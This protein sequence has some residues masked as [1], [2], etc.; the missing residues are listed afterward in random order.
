VELL[1]S[2]PSDFGVEV[3]VRSYGNRLIVQHDPFLD[4]EDLTDWLSAYRHSTLILNVKEEGLEGE[5]IKLMSRYSIDD[6]F[7]LDQSFPYIVKWAR[8]GE[9]RCAVRVSEYESIQTALSM[10][11]L[12][13]WVWL[14]SFTSFLFEVRDLIA[15]KESGFKLCLVSPELQGRDVHSEAIS[16]LGRLSGAGSLIDAVCTKCP[17]VWKALD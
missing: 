5:L 1:R 11:G 12:V 2:V 14:D 6:F 4:G 16:I 7:F 17:D 15:L 13:Q 3:D 10:S 8:S 9:S